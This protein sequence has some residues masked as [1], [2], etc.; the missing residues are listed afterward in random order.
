MEWCKKHPNTIIHSLPMD[1][2]DEVDDWRCAVAEHT[3]LSVGVEPL[4]H[5]IIRAIN[6]AVDLFGTEVLNDIQVTH[7]EL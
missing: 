3:T 5:V 6:K 2:W 1:E 4:P 7:D